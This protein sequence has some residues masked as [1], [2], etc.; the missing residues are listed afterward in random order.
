MES[1]SEANYVTCSWESPI[2]E[3]SLLVIVW[4]IGANKLEHLSTLMWIRSPNKVLLTL[5][6][7]IGIEVTFDGYVAI[8]SIFKFVFLPIIVN[9]APSR[10]LTVVYIRA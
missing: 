6:G 2:V 9:F 10:F 1:L 8:S 4:R 5:F 7:Q 3:T